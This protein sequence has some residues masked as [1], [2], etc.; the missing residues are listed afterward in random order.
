MFFPFFPF[1]IF[2]YPSFMLSN[3]LP[4]S[5]YLNIRP[6]SLSSCIYLSLSSSYYLCMW[7]WQHIHPIFIIIYQHALC[8]SM[9]CSYV[10]GLVQYEAKGCLNPNFHPVFTSNPLAHPYFSEKFLL[11]PPPLLRPTTPAF[12]PLPPPPSSPE[13]WCHNSPYFPVPPTNK[14]TNM[15]TNTHIFICC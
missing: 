14:H 11:P 3:S 4:H 8:V 13:R 15:H 9:F 7:E 1:P 5:L 12:S 10:C 2:F 6:L